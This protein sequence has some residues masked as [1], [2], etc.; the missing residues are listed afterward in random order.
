MKSQYKSAIKRLL[1]RRV[2]LP[3]KKTKRGKG[4]GPHKRQQ[5]LPKRKKSLK[6]P[7]AAPSR[8]TL[9]LA[10]GKEKIG[11]PGALLKWAQVKKIREQKTGA[12][13]K[14]N[15]IETRGKTGGFGRILK[16]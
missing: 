5:T 11:K 13:G 6:L 1:L 14:F 12:A 10:E 16:I 7:D 3:R 8:E 2:V 15:L 4:A 9:P